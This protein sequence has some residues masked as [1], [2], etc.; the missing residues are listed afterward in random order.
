MRRRWNSSGYML[1][2][3]I[4]STCFDN[5]RAVTNLFFFFFLFMHELQVTFVTCA[6]R[7]RCC[8]RTLL[9]DCLLL[10]FLL[11][12]KETDPCIGEHYSKREIKK[13]MLLALLFSCLLSLRFT[14]RAF[15]YPIVLERMRV[16]V[17]V[18][19]GQWR[20]WEWANAAGCGWKYS[21]HHPHP[22]FR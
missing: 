19:W 10:L 17:W 6:K 13:S 8:L 4:I 2:Y 5:M 1:S 20:G 14:V 21:F 9:S 7:T 3:L 22:T 18:V 12:W 16:W 11:R 15:T